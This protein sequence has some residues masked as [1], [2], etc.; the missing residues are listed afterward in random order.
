MAKFELTYEQYM[1][2]MVYEL[3]NRLSSECSVSILKDEIG[4]GGIKTFM[5]ENP[6][7]DSLRVDWEDWHYVFDT[8]GIEKTYREEQ[9]VNEFADMLV[10]QIKE[11][12]VK[13]VIK[14]EK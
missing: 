8:K 1:Y 6:Q 2:A 14:K 11:E 5:K 12:F 3:T 13:Q 10:H 4:Y 7:Y 9:S